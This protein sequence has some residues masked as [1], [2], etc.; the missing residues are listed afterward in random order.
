MGPD[1]DGGTSD[2][3]HAREVA[4]VLLAALTALALTLSTVAVWVRATALDTDRFMAIV[5]PV[6]ADDDVAAAVAD[7]VTA[8]TLEL[9][10][11]D[12]R[13]EAVLVAAQDR[14]AGA[15]ADAL[16]LGP[17]EL[18]L[19]GALGP[20]EGLERFAEP[21]AAGVE[22]RIEDGVDRLLGSQEVRSL[23]T[24]AI[25]VAHARAV[26]LVRG[27]LDELPGITVEEGVVAL[28][29]RPL[30]GR[31]LLEL[32]EEV[33]ELLRIEVDV[34]AAAEDPASVVDTIALALDLDLAPSFAR[35]PV[36][37]ESEL[38]AVQDAVRGLDRNVWAMVVATAVLAIATA[39]V[40][41]RPRRAV[42][43][44][45]TG[46]LVAG[47][48]SVVGIR[49]LVTRLGDLGGTPEAS[50]AIVRVA[51]ATVGSLQSALLVVVG[52]AVATVVVLRVMGDRRP[53]KD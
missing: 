50:L 34:T 45:A 26:L 16:D 49:L 25:E 40:A 7:R 8:D 29:L 22:Q 11:V 28:D 23:L 15:V 12:D 13:I 47:G 41:Q 9:L 51:D 5:E 32:R 2:P 42:V 1:T 6:I 18:A 48:L 35:I 52:A 20:D 30:I 19:L 21:L 31:V 44:L 37:A 53:T 38:V 36:T 46:A 24:D 33:L 4:T 27:E 39:V 17:V 43:A 10:A 14:V 3:S